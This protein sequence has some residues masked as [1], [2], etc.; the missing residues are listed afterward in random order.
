MSPKIN[1]EPATA[2][3]SAAAR[4]DRLELARS[5]AAE[6]TLR[7]GARRT[8]AGAPVRNVFVAAPDADTVPPL[9]S[10]LRGGGRGG[11]LRL[12]LYLGLL[13]LNA[14]PPHESALPARAWAALLGLEDHEIK[15][16]RRIQQAAHDLQGRGFITIRDRGGRPNGLTILDDA[17]TG[18]PYTSPSETYNRMQQQGAPDSVL[19]QHRYFRIPSSIWTD[20]HMAT[21][22]GPGLAMLLVLL[23]ERRGKDTDVWFTPDLARQ[24]YNLADSTRSNGLQE[25]RDRQLLSTRSISISETGS[26][27]TFKRQRNTHRLLLTSD[28]P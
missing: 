27:I 14:T 8:K 16:V 3:A 4:G 10:L 17:G 2:L 28:P 18:A 9:A 23:C 24:R 11:H 12:K 5:A 21:L 20:G 1:E 25:L 13:W 22:T 6:F 19:W 26:F 15:G 7:L